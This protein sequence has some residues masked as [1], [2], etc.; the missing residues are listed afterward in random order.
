MF[1]GPRNTQFCEFSQ[2]NPDHSLLQSESA[3]I[4][5]EQI[6]KMHTNSAAAEGMGCSGKTLII[7]IF[8][9]VKPLEILHLSTSE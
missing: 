1:V 7:L 5:D 4:C 9:L 8:L 6:Q 3:Q 2:I